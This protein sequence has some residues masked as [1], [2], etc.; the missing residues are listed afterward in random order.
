MLSVPRLRQIVGDQCDFSDAELERFRDGLY[1]IARNLVDEC[2]L[3]PKKPQEPCFPTDEGTVIPFEEA[4][5]RLPE[6]DRIAVEERAAIHEFDGNM[7]RAD[8]ERQ[9]LQ[10]HQKSRETS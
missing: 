7:T 3:P 4:M 10:D 8:A 1:D 9:A 6:N 2:K 5:R